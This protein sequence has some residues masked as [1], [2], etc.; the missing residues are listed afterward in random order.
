VFA[1]EPAA[2]S[3]ALAALLFVALLGSTGVDLSGSGILGP[4]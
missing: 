2:R 4:G 3:L 1:D